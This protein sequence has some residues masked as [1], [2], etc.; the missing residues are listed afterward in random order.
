MCSIGYTKGFY[1]DPRVD[2]EV[3]EK[4][5]EDLI[6]LSGNMHGE[7]ASKLLNIGESQAEEALLYWKS[8]FDKDFYL[9]MMRHGQE[10]E[11]RVNENLLEFSK[12][13]NINMRLR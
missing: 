1:Y 5:K 6:V 9:E 2:R 11:K 7:I 4:Y 10:D 8:L 12:K 13:H 3:V